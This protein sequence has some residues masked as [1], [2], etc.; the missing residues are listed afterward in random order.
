MHG[1]AVNFRA[2]FERSFV[3]VEPFECGQQRRMDIEHALRP[4]RDKAGREQPHE[5]GEANEIDAV[6]LKHC[7]HRGIERGA[8]LAE[9]RVID[10]FGGDAGGAR[11][12]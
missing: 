4:L 11:D 9:R 7:L 10:H 12:R 1:G 3:G 2:G 8:V 5:A 6:L